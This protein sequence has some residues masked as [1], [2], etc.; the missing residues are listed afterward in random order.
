MD[1]QSFK[2]TVVAATWWEHR[3]FPF[4]SLPLE[5]RIH[6]YLQL[7]VSDP[8]DSPP[9]EP[10]LLWHDR[11][12]RGGKSLGIYPQIL[13]T[14]KQIN[15]EATPLL[16]ERNKFQLS[17]LSHEHRS[18]IA[19]R[20]IDPKSQALIEGELA[21]VS[22]WHAEPGLISPRCLQRLA[23]IELV[24]SPESLWGTTYGGVYWS[25]AGR[26]FE[27]LL[28]ILADADEAGEKLERRKKFVITVRKSKVNGHESMM[29]PP[30]PPTLDDLRKNGYRFNPEGEKQMAKEICSLVEKVSSKRDVCIFEIREE[31]GRIAGTAQVS[32]FTTREV[33]LDDFGD[34]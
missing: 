11:N 9:E 19:P 34:M 16:Y 23:Y 31:M 21:R 28:N 1:T 30:P 14:S 5:L 24:L 2:P 22:R 29:F 18:C 13:R 15:V 33:T 32:S 7:L 27:D 17:L 12:G 3:D 10:L 20:R 25:N 8:K 4:L 26:V 6:I